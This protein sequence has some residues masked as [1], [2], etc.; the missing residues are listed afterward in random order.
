MQSWVFFFFSS[1]RRHTSWPRDWSSDVCSSD[2]KW[3]S[4]SRSNCGS[5]RFGMPWVR[6]HWMTSRQIATRSG[7]VVVVAAAWE[8]PR[9]EHPDS[10]ASRSTRSRPTT[11]RLPPPDDRVACS[12]IVG[13]PPVQ[14]PRAAAGPQ[15]G[16]HGRRRVLLLELPASVGAGELELAV[17]LWVGEVGQ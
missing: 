10:P 13:D 17:T 12:A 16:L 4:P 3:G 1:R 11:A 8:R 2:L 9:A 7:W 6:M 14:H 15:G 5:G